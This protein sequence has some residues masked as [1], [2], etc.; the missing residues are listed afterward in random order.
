MKI[1]SERTRRAPIPRVILSEFIKIKEL[2]L[3]INVG[4]LSK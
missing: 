2:K 4:L 3:V 1:I